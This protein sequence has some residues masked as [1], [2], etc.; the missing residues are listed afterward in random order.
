MHSLEKKPNFH[1]EKFKEYT[2]FFCFAGVCV[3]MFSLSFQISA[4]FTIGLINIFETRGAF[5]YWLDD[6][7]AYFYI[8]RCD[9]FSQVLTNDF[10]HF[11]RHSTDLCLGAQVSNMRALE[12]YCSFY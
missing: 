3:A 4:S 7:S 9:C 5:I 12:H 10:R 1:L 6:N 11:F 2:W 8:R